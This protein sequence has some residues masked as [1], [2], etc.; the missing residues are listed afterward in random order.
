MTEPMLD[1]LTYTKNLEDAGFN[2]T[3]AE[4]I[5]RGNMSMLA[6]RL[7]TL[8]TREYFDARFDGLETQFESIDRRFKSIDG[9]FKAIDKR[10]ETVDKRFEKIEKRLDA[11]DTIKT[12]VNLLTWMMGVVILVL[13]VPQLQGLFSVG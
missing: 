1:V 8:V 5:A 9:R 7:E 13:V 4:A 3:Q 12:Q 2:R 10:F 11:L 6:Q